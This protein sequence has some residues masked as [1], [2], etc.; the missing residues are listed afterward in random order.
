MIMVIFRQVIQNCEQKEFP[1]YWLIKG[2]HWEIVRLDTQYKVRFYGYCKDGKK[3]R[4]WKGG[5]EVVAVAYD[6][7]VPPALSTYGFNTFNCNTL[8]LW[9]SFPSNEFNF[10][11]FNRGE[12]QS[13]LAKR[14]QANYITSDLY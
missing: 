4:V 12:H 11:Q 8:R 1:D 10:E 3:I 7:A 14:D 5:E 13:A 2:N 9:K 6:T